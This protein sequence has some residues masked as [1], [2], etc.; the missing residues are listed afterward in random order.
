[1]PSEKSTKNLNQKTFP[2]RYEVR[3]EVIP[4]VGYS[5][6]NAQPNFLQARQLASFTNN[7]YDLRLTLTW[8][9]YERAKGDWQVGFNRRTFRTLMAGSINPTNA[10]FSPNHYTTRF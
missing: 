10:L 8:P 5:N 2:F 7:L 6:A 1:M 4:F 9:L 3:P